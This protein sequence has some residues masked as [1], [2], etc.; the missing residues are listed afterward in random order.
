MQKHFKRLSLAS[1]VLLQEQPSGSLGCLNAWWSSHQQN[2]SSGTSWE[3]EGQ[4][5]GKAEFQVQIQV[6]LF[7][8]T[9]W[10]DFTLFLCS[11]I[12]SLFFPV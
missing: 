3:G 1:F 8:L 7:I 5:G 11:C 9:V 4:K 2:I 12:W 10:R 6:L